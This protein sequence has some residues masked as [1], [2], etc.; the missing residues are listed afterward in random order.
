HTSDWHLGSSLESASRDEE[1]R[2]F[3]EWLLVTLRD[4]AIDVLLLA[5]DVFHYAQP[6]AEAQRLYYGFLARVGAET[7]VRQMVVIGGNHDSASRLDAPREVLDALRIHVVGG[8]TG[9]PSTWERCLCPIERPGGGVDAVVLA[10]PF[11]HE[12]RLGI[13]TTGRSPAEIT[14]DFRDEFSRLY[15]RLADLAEERWPGAP[16]IATGHMTCVGAEKGEYGTE[17][18]QVGTIGGLPGDIFDPRLEYIALGHIHRM[19][20][21]EGTRARYSGSPLAMNVVEARSQRFVIRVELD[22]SLPAGQR[23][24]THKIPVPRWR[25]I[26]EVTGPT[27]VVLDRLRALESP[28]ELPPFVYVKLEVD[29]YL[30]D[31]PFRVNEAIETH[32]LK[33]RPR[34]VEVHQK[35]AGREDA[36]TD[37]VERTSLR[38]MKPEEVFVR[39]HQAQFKS[40]PGDLL[41]T[42]FRTVLS[43]LDE[44]PVAEEGGA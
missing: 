3:L 34:V 40:P 8:L 31:G 22:A 6:S 26:L 4:E 21:V 23:A 44:P 7:K 38:G 5:G 20:P 16:L 9:E 33:T 13:R 12:F 17:I 39:L 37:G 24:T 19:F 29:E 2:R 10:V 42:A 15:T 27:E 30:T 35:V 18:H 43:Q 32:P 11:V 41:L 28:H 25:E 14:A 1:H 36:P